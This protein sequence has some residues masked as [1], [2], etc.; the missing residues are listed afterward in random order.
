MKN[1]IS[2]ISVILL[3]VF[4]TGAMA[5]GDSF[6]AKRGDTSWGIAKATCEN[7]MKWKA[8]GLP[9]RLIAGKTYAVN[10]NKCVARPAKASAKPVSA[11][12]VEVKPCNP[13]RL[14]HFNE[15]AF[16]KSG[17]NRL[18]ALAWLGF[19]SS[20]AKEFV[21]KYKSGT[22][23]PHTINPGDI[24]RQMVGRTRYLIGKIIFTG[25]KPESAKR[26]TASTGQSVIVPDACENWATD[27]K[28]PV[29]V[30]MM[31]PPIPVEVPT[32]AT[33]I[34]ADPVPKPTLVVSTP[35]EIP[36]AAI[37]P[38]PEVVP[39]VEPG[40]RTCDRG[41]ELSGGVFAWHNFLAEGRGAY[42]ENMCWN[43]IEAHPEYAWGYGFYGLVAPGE[44]NVSTYKWDEKRLAG[45]VGIQKNFLNDEGREEQLLGKLRLGYE[46]Q[47]GSNAEGYS[48]SQR[49]WMLG[50]YGE[51][52]KYLNADGDR[53]G[54]Q[55]ESW[56]ALDKDATGGEAQS[57]TSYQLLGFYDTKLSKDG[58]WSLRA[59][60]GPAYTE[61]DKTWWLRIIPEFRYTM[62]NGAL[63][64]FGPYGNAVLSSQTYVEGAPNTSGRFARVELGGKFRKDAETEQMKAFC[65]LY[66]MQ[67]CPVDVNEPVEA[68]A[69]TAPVT[70]GW[71]VLNLEKQIKK[72]H[73]QESGPPQA[74][75]VGDGWNFLP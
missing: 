54:A 51:W 5:G 38:T 64:A 55:F 16:R 3:F 58:R 49:N 65:A 10:P 25:K 42:V 12:S 67:H 2:L 28:K 30:A 57:R 70:D 68:S 33:V 37:E 24:F 59:S 41:Y 17:R 62:D 21:G 34:V 72:E 69:S 44:S 9:K 7:G 19:S 8:L 27:L 50:T 36:V 6:V 46:W 20:D 40:K 43:S 23:E 29:P 60:V 35:I 45:Q 73:N 15:D 1:L 48:F 32:Y 18:D 74:K 61:W 13:C 63:L 31:P 4:S 47:N 66:E 52:R 11:Q 22:C 53:I 14:P 39:V 56:M 75:S 26:C 71:D